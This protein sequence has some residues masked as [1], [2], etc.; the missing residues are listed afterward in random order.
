MCIQVE[1]LLKMSLSL[2][3]YIQ[4]QV[5]MSIGDSGDA[6]YISE[7]SATVNTTCLDTSHRVQNAAAHSFHAVLII[8]GGV[9]PL[10]STYSLLLIERDF[11]R[12]PVLLHQKKNQNSKSDQEREMIMIM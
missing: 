6:F 10:L 12:P 7:R 8:E 3:D 4:R 5:M 9:S 2:L 1:K 11:P